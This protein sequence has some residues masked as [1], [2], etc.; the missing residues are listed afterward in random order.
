MQ[1]KP[2]SLA[3]CWGS[4]H[5]SCTPEYWTALHALP[6]EM[7]YHTP[8]PSAVSQMSQGIWWVWPVHRTH[9]LVLLSHPL[10]DCWASTH[11]WILA[12][13]PDAVPLCPCV[14]LGSCPM[15]LVPKMLLDVGRNADL[16]E[17]WRPSRQESYSGREGWDP[18]LSRPIRH[19]SP[20]SPD[21][22]RP[23]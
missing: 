21:A 16:Q 1:V 11:S 22:S 20:R 9:P 4:A 15:S 23:V 8:C 5:G 7:V 10:R 12:C 13:P 3:C 6:Y 17:T 2:R 18:P 14:L 19:F